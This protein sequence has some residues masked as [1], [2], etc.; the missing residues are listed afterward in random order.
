MSKPFAPSTWLLDQMIA[1][2]MA[3]CDADIEQSKLQRDAR[4]AMDAAAAELQ[5]ESLRTQA[6]NERFER[7]IA[8]NARNH[9]T[10]VALANGCHPKP[11][12][13]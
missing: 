4:P 3:S 7:A 9:P 6:L 8:I 2:A 5:A 12:N 1:K 13:A 11:R 10:R